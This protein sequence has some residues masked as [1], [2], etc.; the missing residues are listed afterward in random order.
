VRLGAISADLKRF[1]AA[2]VFASLMGAGLL[3][4]QA[5][6][7]T[8]GLDRMLWEHRF[9]AS[10]RPVTGDLL[11]VDID[12][13]SLEQLG[14]WPIPRRTYADLIDN[15]SEAGVTEIVFD[16]DFSLVSTP[17]DDAIFAAS[18]ERAGNVSL[19]AFRQAATGAEDESEEILNQP[20]AEF[21]EFAWPVVVMVPVEA[22]SRIWRNIY[23]FELNGVEELS[24]AAYLGGHTGATSE[25]FWL[26]Y[27][28]AIDQMPRVSMI[29]VLEGDVANTTLFG[30]KVIIGASAQELRDLFPTPVYGIL[31]GAMIQAL[32]AETLM[33]DRALIIRGA[34][35]AVLSVLLLFVLLATTKRTGLST[36]L[37]VLVGFMLLLELAGYFALQER[38][39]LISTASAQVLLVA[40]AIVIIFQ[41]LGL[42]KLISQLYQ[43][44][45]RNTVRMLGQVFDDSFDAIVVIDRSEKITASSEVA[46]QLF[47]LN[48]IPN[49]SGREALPAELVDD[50]VAVLSDTTEGKPEPKLLKMTGENG[51]LRVIEYV[52]TRSEKTVTSKK[53]KHARENEALAC[54]T[55]RDI[56]EEY[57][58]NKRLAYLA[59]FDP[60]TGL[61]NRNGFEDEMPATVERAG[62]DGQVLCLVQLSI[63]NL[64]QI[65]A[66]LG[67]SY[68]DLLRKAVADRVTQHFGTEVTWAALTAD[69]FAAAYIS[70]EGEV[71]AERFLE[72][73]QQVVGKDYMI[74]GSRISVRLDFGYIVDH[75]ASEIDELLKKSGN[76]LAL[77]RRSAQLA[78]V[79]FRPEMNDTLQRRR[80]LE[81]E[82]FK[83]ISRN[84]LRMVYQP[85][86]DLRSRE[87]IGV[88]AL[89]RW[90]HGELGEISPVEFIPISEENGFIVELGAWT[91][92][93]SMEEVGQWNSNI[94]LSVNVSA[95]QFSRGDIVATVEDAL[96]AT[97][98]PADRFDLE[99]TESLF[100]DETIDVRSSMQELAELGCCFS[101]DDFGTG[102]SSLAYLQNYP[103][104]KIKLDRMFISKVTTNKKDVA[105][106][107]AVL[108]MA[109]AFG[110]ETVMEGI[111]TE[112]QTETLLGLGCRVGQGYL[113]G[114]PMSAA[115][116]AQL[117]RR[118]A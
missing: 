56:T 31:P 13:R 84:E 83:S 65:I 16:I 91:L 77:S 110:M 43:I 39:V 100:I 5:V 32:G 109:K 47:G 101:L 67:F 117:L 29:D 23:G 59:R 52:V 69:V 94:N 8:D 105:L 15:L 112:E 25:A 107:E 82:L 11:F 75:Y 53:G 51:Q 46:R 40:C 1:L 108:H 14:I 106:I 76:A 19:A 97:K 35:P 26:D 66:S 81:T 104:S 87:I 95:L 111:E 86:I 12:A 49:A 103:F 27:S 116:L 74:E 3:A 89:L 71:C 4:L 96:K 18:I 36:K 92:H 113:F 85:L 20:I 90:R 88:E 73:V 61:F 2:I 68:G 114:R 42:R 10:E 62:F 9:T 102:Y 44:S 63:S 57:E 28:I 55:C 6:R 70:D 79:A 7:V 24:A 115:D 34:M 30:K 22:D 118:S 50:A 45:Q 17:E 64:D 48:A 99:I 60:V 21:L 41:E 33:Q 37:A 72:T 80:S 54:L 38:P 58:A 78:C 98:F 93:R